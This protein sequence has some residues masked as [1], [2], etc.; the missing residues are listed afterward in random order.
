MRFKLTFRYIIMVLISTILLLGSAFLVL[1]FFEDNDQNNTETNPTLFAYNF[2]NDIRQDENEEIYLS[3]EGREALI[4][5]EAWLQI[6]N[7]EGYVMQAYNTPDYVADHY[8]P[9]EITYMNQSRSYNPS[10]L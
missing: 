6:L 1:T 5:E 9:I 10:Y 3:E 4:A 8:S 2:Q 7:D